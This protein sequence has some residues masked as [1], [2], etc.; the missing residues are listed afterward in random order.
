MQAWQ[1]RARLQIRARYLDDDREF[2]LSIR[3]VGVVTGV[4]TRISPLVLSLESAT[5]L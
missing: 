1:L 4:G 2:S 5:D 3:V